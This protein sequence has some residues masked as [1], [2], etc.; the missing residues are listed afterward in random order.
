[1]ERKMAIGDN[2]GLEA[3]EIG[4]TDALSYTSGGY[5]EGPSVVDNLKSA[6]SGFG[7]KLV[8]L[9]NGGGSI[10]EGNTSSDILG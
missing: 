4:N 5:E 1:M 8:A 2:F 9:F 7:E 10:G 3:V 6:A